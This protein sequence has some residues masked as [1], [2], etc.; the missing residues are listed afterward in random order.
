M[1][2]YGHYSKAVLFWLPL[3]PNTPF[4]VIVACLLKAHD[5]KGKA[6]NHY[7]M[8]HADKV[9]LISFM[10]ISEYSIALNHH[11]SL[12]REGKHHCILL[13]RGLHL[14][15]WFSAI[16][17]SIWYM[18]EG[19]ILPATLFC[20][21]YLH[22][23][24]SDDWT[25]SRRLHRICRARSIS[26]NLHLQR[27]WAVS[28]LVFYTVHA[29][30]GTLRPSVAFWKQVLPIVIHLCTTLTRLPCLLDHL[31]STP[32]RSRDGQQT[33]P[34]HLCV[35]GRYCNLIEHFGI[36]GDYKSPKQNKNTFILMCFVPIIF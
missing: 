30:K 26:A 7:L 19:H 10:I 8:R 33:H 13:Q 23:S 31:R 15:R 16:M 21:S 20:S 32:W 11:A 27:N 2:I 24:C 12:H 35:D 18:F 25:N 22:K 5:K 3:S 34:T 28:C 6:Y 17:R 14:C 4:T 29:W 36:W 9:F 1:Y